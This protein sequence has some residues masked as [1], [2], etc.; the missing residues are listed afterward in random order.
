MT[1]SELRRRERRSEH[2]FRRQVRDRAFGHPQELAIDLLVVLAI[3][4][5]AAVDAAAREGGA[6]A[7]FD[8]HLGDRPAA[9]LA[10]GHLGQPREVGELWIVIAAILGLRTGRFVPGR[11]IAALPTS[12]RI[13]VVSPGS[14]PAGQAE[15]PNS[16]GSA[17]AVGGLTL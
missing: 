4:R 14:C 7:E 5:R 13:G 3:A 15:V 17:N 1:P 2:P 11:D 8:R 10:A 6:L 16:S 12:L 9:D